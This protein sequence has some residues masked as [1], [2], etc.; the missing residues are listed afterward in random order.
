MNKEELLE[1]MNRIEIKENGNNINS[2]YKELRKIALEIDADDLLKRFIDYYELDLL[3]HKSYEIKGLI[4][5][6]DFLDGVN[7]LGSDVYYLNNRG[8]ARDVSANDLYTLWLD[9]RARIKKL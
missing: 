5:A 6:K 7:N 9:L 2:I 8:N 1:R 4:T 3:F